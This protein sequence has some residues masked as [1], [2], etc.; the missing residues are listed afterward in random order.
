LPSLEKLHQ[1]FKGRNFVLIGIDINEKRE[2]VLKSVRRN[3]LSFINLLD[4]DGQVASMYGVNSTPAK[5]LIDKEG[6]MIGAALGY[7]DWEQDEFI[8]L[9]EELMKQ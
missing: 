9:I 6:N 8:A 4:S 7:R 5:F 1:Q 2:T 3:G